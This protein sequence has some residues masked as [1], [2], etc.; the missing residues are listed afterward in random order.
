MSSFLVQRGHPR[1][2]ASHRSLIRCESAA[3]AAVWFVSLQIGEIGEIFE[4]EQVGFRHS[5]RK[6]GI[7]QTVRFKIHRT[8]IVFGTVD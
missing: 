8:L 3:I 2:S 7:E 1:A 4:T 5:P 6:T